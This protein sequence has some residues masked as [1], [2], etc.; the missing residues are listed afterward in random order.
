MKYPQPR[1]LRTLL[2]LAAMLTGNL[3]FA[4][5]DFK[6]TVSPA[7]LCAPVTVSL[8]NTSTGSALT[9]TW[10][11]G[12][13][14]TSTD[15]NPTV[16]YTSGGVKK[17]TL[18]AHNYNVDNSVFKTFTI[19]DIPVVNFSADVTQS[20]SFYTATFTDQTPGGTNRIWDF[21]DGTATV[22]TSAATITH[23]YTKAGKFDVKVTVSNINGCS[24]QLTKPAYINVSLPVLKMSAPV[25]GCVPY[26]AT[27]TATSTNIVNDPATG[28]TW[29]FG[30][31]SPAQNGGA[32][33]N[34]TY[35]Q[36]GTYNVAVTVKTA[37]GCTIRTSFDKQVHTGNPPIGVSFTA[38]PT[39]ACTGEPVRLLANA[40]YADTYS[41]DFGDGS[42]LETATNDIKHGF[43]ANGTL[44]VN[45]KAGSNGCYTNA[46]S[47]PVTINGPVSS[48]TYTRNCSERTEFNFTN[49]ATNTSAA[50]TYQWDFGDNSPLETTK[51][52]THRYSVPGK[53]TVRLTVFDNNGTC[54][55]SSFQTVY[56]FLADFTTGISS[57]C[58]GNKVTYEVLN[59]PQE[60]VASYTWIFGDGTTYTG[61]EQSYTKAWNTAGTYDDQLVIKYNNPAYCDDIVTRVANIRI[62]APQAD[63]TL[64]SGLC[65]G[66]PST[67]KNN[68]VTSPNTP[69][70][71][72]KWDLG[73][74]Q[75]ST[76]QTP[77]PLKYAA[78]GNYQV[79]LVITDARNCM[80]SISKTISINPSPFIKVT[81]AQ[82]KIC[83]GNGTTLTATTDA[84]IQWL[85]TNNISCLNCTT[86]TVSPVTNT[87]YLAEATNPY[88]CTM[89]DSVDISVVPKVAL[90]VASND[91]KVCYG[92]S[93]KLQASGATNFKWTP[94][95][96]LTNDRIPDP[97]STPTADI[98]YQ[99]TAT[100]D[101]MCPYSAP[102]SVKVSV[103]PVPD[104]D[105][106][107]SQT[108]PVGSVVKL[109]ATGSGDVVKWQWSPT[110][111]LDCSFCPIVTAAVRKPMTYS[112]TGT[113]AFGCTKSA[114]VTVDLVCNSDAIYIPNTFSPNGDGV[115]DIFYPR[116]K[117]ISFVKSLRIFNRWG[118]EVYR[119]E[120]F[121]TDDKSRGWDGTFNGKPQPSDVYIYFLEAYCDTNDFLQLK[122]NLTLLR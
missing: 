13:G 113:N 106:G 43:N 102:V 95:D 98:T 42:T 8:T 111:Y 35:T 9:Y 74:G 83:E 47:I 20:C 90:T 101:P 22:T 91:I 67:F 52:A 120:K 81:T 96:G 69:I 99:V 118:Q 49:T 10:D 61:P 23:A 40:Q 92:S 75:T 25:A 121:N 84:S 21:G 28:Y 11:F 6:Y 63:F 59:I 50:A 27:F 85:T 17:I 41:W 114:T 51:D 79:K 68:S 16:I 44:I 38:S 103:K 117:G 109:M 93:T 39:N 88:G 73:N 24:S 56:Y 48:F 62:L 76:A 45:M 3:L 53:Y 4:Q 105:A 7:S 18:T 12:D 89:R 115:N 34:H 33:I 64:A 104:V 107:K 108:V 72:W 66:Q 57:I 58:R 30:D 116:G 82:A 70:T 119:R 55:H 112:V 87:R 15:P 122:G 110:D 5:V 86:P 80:D 14:R 36:T 19:G 46:P 94:V 97:I 1:C 31:G 37:S 100:N 71:N 2:L 26:N 29:E 32:T 60:L 78:S 65:A 54:S 77:A